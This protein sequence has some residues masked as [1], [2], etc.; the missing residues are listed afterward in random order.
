MSWGATPIHLDVPTG[1]ADGRVR[2][3]LRIAAH[4]GDVRPG[5]LVAILSG[6]DA[7]ADRATDTLKFVRV[8]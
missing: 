1:N 5:D 8:P 2:E 4:R 6:S 3:A 7:I